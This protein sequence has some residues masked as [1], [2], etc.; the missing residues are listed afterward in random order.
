MCGDR[1]P[2]V[3][4][5]KTKKGKLR[6]IFQ[7]VAFLAVVEVFF[8]FGISGIRMIGSV[9][10]L[11]N[12]PRP[13]IPGVFIPAYV[14]AHGGV[15]VVFCQ[16]GPLQLTLSNWD[17]VTAFVP[18]GI[19]GSI[20]IFGVIFGRSFCGWVCPVGFLSDLLTRFRVKVLKRGHKEPSK[21]LHDRLTFLKYGFLVT[22]LLL[23]LSI[24]LTRLFAPDIAAAYTELWP[25]EFGL[26]L[27][28]KEPM[29]A[30]CPA[31]TFFSFW[32]I[33]FYRT[34]EAIQGAFDLGMFFSQSILYLTVTVFFVIGVLLT[35]RAWCRYLCPQGA[36]SS[37][38]HRISLF[39]K[40]KDFD[41]CVK[42]GTCTRTCPMKISTVEEEEKRDR[43]QDR[44]CIMCLQCVEKCPEKALKL[45]IGTKSFLPLRGD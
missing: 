42:C 7:F 33:A 36:I 26:A 17:P 45:R 43:V 13:W 12:V 34:N 32:P 5:C 15:C 20:L 3:I 29:C 22:I 18:F 8:V 11:E 35:R 44:E 16:L 41:K 21:N 40:T 25:T 28:T 9:P 30:T 19:L 39:S 2:D 37:L 10:W 24:G 6:L 31:E 14:A 27:Y 38:F 1:F 23:T 4:E